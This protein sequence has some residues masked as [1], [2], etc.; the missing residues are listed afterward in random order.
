MSLTSPPHIV[1][2]TSCGLCMLSALLAP[3]QTLDAFGSVL[4]RALQLQADFLL[5]RIAVPDLFVNLMPTD[6]RAC[7]PCSCWRIA[8]QDCCA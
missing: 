3:R 2:T 5:C 4:K 7:R 1:P 8:L 6:I